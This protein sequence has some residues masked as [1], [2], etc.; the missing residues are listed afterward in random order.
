MEGVLE[1]L[2]R[3][4]SRHCR[5]GCWATYFSRL[6]QSMTFCDLCYSNNG[7]AGYEWPSVALRFCFWD[8]L[9]LL[10]HGPLSDLP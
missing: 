3:R 7:H 5:F 2:I 8:S 4:S 1:A 9:A 10:L 6:W